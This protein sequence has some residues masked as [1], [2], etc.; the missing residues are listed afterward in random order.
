[1][2]IN[3]SKD[4]ASAYFQP[5]SIDKSGKA[6]FLSYAY[7]N[8]DFVLAGISIGEDPYWIIF[9]KHS[10]QEVV[11]KD[12]NCEPYQ[13]SPGADAVYGDYF[14]KVLPAFVISIVKENIE[15]KKAFLKPN[16]P[17]YTDYLKLMEAKLDDNPVVILFKIKPQVKIRT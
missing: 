17:K 2:K 15:K 5:G 16:H 6:Y 9:D 12:I 13:I 10:M 14:C 1:M 7:E 3:L 11:Y 8:S 4:E